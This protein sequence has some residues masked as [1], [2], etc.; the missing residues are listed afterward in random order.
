MKKLKKIV[1][2]NPR[3]KFI[4]NCL[5]HSILR[6]VAIEKSR[7]NKLKA[8]YRKESNDSMVNNISDQINEL[9]LSVENSICECKSCTAI[10]RD[11]VYVPAIQLVFEGWYCVDCYEKY[12]KDYARFYQMSENERE[13]FKYKFVLQNNQTFIKSIEN[14]RWIK[15]GELFPVEPPRAEFKVNDYITL[16][17]RGGAPILFVAGEQFTQC[18]GLFVT[19]YGKENPYSNID[20]ID[21]VSEIKELENFRDISMRDYHLS[22]KTVFWGHCSN[23]QAWYENDYDTRLLHS[24]LSFPLL[25]KLT[26]AGDLLA[27]RVFKKEIAKRYASNNAAVKE[28]LRIGGYLGYLSK[29]ELEA[30]LN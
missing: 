11:M 23:I 13:G 19:I 27:K 2:K 22:A 4:R 26:E 8:F 17:L 7:L 16:Q 10:E 14:W 5:R 25:K 20:S 6:A 18:I 28:F 3:L 24:N 30:I 21:D 15:R 12:A 29:E 1:I 9:E